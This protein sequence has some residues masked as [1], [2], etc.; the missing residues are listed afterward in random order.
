[1]FPNLADA[2]L[3]AAD[4]DRDGDMDLCIAGSTNYGLL[5][6][7]SGLFRNEGAGHFSPM[8]TGLPLV[9]YPLLLWG[10]FDNDGW[11]DLL[12]SGLLKVGN[13]FSNI[14][15]IFHNDGGTT[16]SE[17]ATLA[18]I[19]S[20]KGQLI[21]L[22]SD[23]RLDVVLLGSSPPQDLAIVTQLYLNRGHGQFDPIGPAQV[24]DRYR[25]ASFAA[26]D[27]THDARPDLVLPQFVFRNNFPATN[28]P[29]GPPSGL[30]ADPKAGAVTL[31]WSAATD[32]NQSGGL[33]YN[34][35]VGTRSG[36]VDVMSPLADPVTGQR[37]VVGQANAGESLQWRLQSLKPGVYFWSVQALDHGGA[38]SAFAPE[39][40]FV[41]A[42][43]RPRI[44][45]AGI[46]NGIVI[47]KV[48]FELAGSFSVMTSPDLHTWN[49]LEPATYA[50]GTT[51]ITLPGT[52]Q[53]AQFF[54]LRRNP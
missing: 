34:L 3:A 7:Y 52:G 8:A 41:I 48:E 6:F 35:R 14:T 26:G 19:G 43:P 33:C 25:S 30:H 17:Y 2:A 21:D 13:T 29:P 47:L 38:G 50:A 22:D 5:A 27:L 20:S 11:P 18:P 1:L 23:G 37:W 16:F 10:D 28:T 36:S 15:K 9:T 24:E 46:G 39:A 45:S 12:V 54:R 44:L 51:N 31:S 53:K 40:S 32:G 49:E 4:F 42:D